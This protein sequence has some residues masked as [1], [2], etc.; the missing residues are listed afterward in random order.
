MDIVKLKKNLNILW[1]YFNEIGG[2][3]EYLLVI[4]GKNIKDR[5]V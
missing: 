2:Y 4:I 3:F 1:K 5:W